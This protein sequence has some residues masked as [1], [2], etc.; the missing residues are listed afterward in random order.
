[1]VDTNTLTEFYLDNINI[2]LPS[3]AKAKQ[4]KIKHNHCFARIVLDNIFNDCWYDHLDKTK[5]AYKQLNKDH[6]LKAF[7][8]INL[9][10]LDDEVINQLNNN[11]LR[12]RNKHIY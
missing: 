7:N 8:I 4:W 11:S 10:L 9:I 5:P 3:I 12:Y 6:L 1:V 2:V